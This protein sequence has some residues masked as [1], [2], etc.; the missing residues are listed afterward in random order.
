[1]NMQ[2]NSVFQG[3]RWYDVHGKAASFPFGHGT[4]YTQFTYSNL[5][6]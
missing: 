3:Y 6:R 1:V 4:L 2:A 5:T